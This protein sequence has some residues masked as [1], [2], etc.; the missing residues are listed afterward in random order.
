LNGQVNGIGGTQK[1]TK[2]NKD[3]SRLSTDE[4]L[5]IKY[6]PNPWDA[7]LRLGLHTY[8]ES[9]T[10]QTT[11]NVKPVFNYK[12]NDWLSANLYVNAELVLGYK[13]GTK[14]AGEDPALFDS[15]E[16]WA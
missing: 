5:Y 16:D 8:A 6:A 3:L 15:L 2:T 10:K 4:W 7:Q 12:F 13:D 14:V 9:S 11:L 1:D